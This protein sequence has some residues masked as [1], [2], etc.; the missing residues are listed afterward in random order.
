MT[1]PTDDTL[2]AM[3]LAMLHAANNSEGYAAV[4][5]YGIGPGG[6]AEMRAVFRVVQDALAAQGAEP[7]ASK[8]LGP[9]KD[10]AQALDE[11]RRACA[12]IIGA[13]PETWP[14][15][16]NAPL[17]IAAA[18]GL[19]QAELNKL[20]TQPTAG[21]IACSE[22]MP[23][24]GQKVLACYRNRADM[25]RTIMAR[26]VAAKSRE[27]YEEH[28][29]LDLVYDEAADCYYWPEGW[30]ETMDN[31]PEFS[32]LVVSEG[33]VTHWQPRPPPPDAAR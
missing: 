14:S 33:E 12:E 9:C 7:V 25:H 15:H 11:L 8:W 32:N 28:S 13:D 23:A 16:G 21:W 31:W 17:A 19:R 5:Q 10:G 29:D 2:Q 18:L 6:D 22:R 1:E 24:S 26:W 20:A 3:M 4:Q 27:G 30:Y